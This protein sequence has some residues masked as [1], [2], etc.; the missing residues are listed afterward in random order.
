MNDDKEQKIFETKEEFDLENETSLDANEE[1]LEKEK[2]N[3]SNKWVSIV[4]SL[5]FLLYSVY[6]YN[7]AYEET[8]NQ[9]L[10]YYNTISGLNYYNSISSYTDW[11]KDTFSLTGPQVYVLEKSNEIY[12][13][14]K[15]DMATVD[16]FTAL[17]GEV[18][19]EKSKKTEEYL[20]WYGENG[21]KYGVVITYGTVEN[22]AYDFTDPL[23]NLYCDEKEGMTK[24]EIITL[25]GEPDSGDTYY[26]STYLYWDSESGLQEACI[27]DGVVVYFLYEEI[28]SPNDGV[29]KGMTKEEVIKLRG[30]P[31]STWLSPGWTEFCWRD[32]NDIEYYVLWEDGSV[33]SISRDLESSSYDNIQLSTEIGT[34]IEDLEIL[35]ENLKDGM[36]FSEVIGIL[37]DKYIELSKGIDSCHCVWYDKKE[38]YINIWFEKSGDSFVVDLLGSVYEAY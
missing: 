16:D 30:K 11:P 12:D 34:E 7:V 28:Y 22:F 10:N 2:N 33:N 9:Q 27:R 4:V 35:K 36:E 6:E 38:N 37:G 5:I 13:S 32:E 23:Y 26:E 17:M 19:S 29:K 14:L 20:Y 25:L 18:D 24:E 3:N 1:N 31:D 15:L 8:Y 21:T